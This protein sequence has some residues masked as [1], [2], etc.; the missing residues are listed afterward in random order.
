MHLPMRST[1]QSPERPGL[2]HQ[3]ARSL[4]APRV[5]RRGGADDGSRKRAP[6]VARRVP[7]ADGRA[8]RHGS[9][10]RH[11]GGTRERGRP[12][13]ARGSSGVGEP[14]GARLVRVRG[15]GPLEAVRSLPPGHEAEVHL[16]DKRGERARQDACRPQAGHRAP[17]RRLREGLRRQRLRPAV[18]SGSAQESQASEPGDGEGGTDRRQAVVDPGRLGLRQ[19]PLPDRQG[20][21][22]GEV[23]EPHVRRPLQGQD[24]VVRRPQPARSRRVLPRR[25]EAVRPDGRRAEEIAGI[26]QVEE[27]PRPHVLVV[28][29]RPADRLRRRRDL[30]RLC[31][32]GRLRG[33]EGEEAA[34]RLHATQGGCA[35]VG[36]RA[37]ARE[38][39]AAGQRSLTRTPMPGA[40][41][42]PVPGSRRT[43]PT[44]RRTRSR[45]P[46]TPGS[47]RRCSSTTRSRSASRSPTSIATSGG[48]RSTRS[49]GTRSRRP[50]RSNHR[51]G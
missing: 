32:A 47:A 51:R 42:R 38:G 11:R 35:L 36:L 19:D 33:D 5:S 8:G 20:E 48:G 39:L 22:E 2:T 24:R 45:G 23:L 37:D 10:R 16:H 43:T 13:T 17:M 29:D 34:G 31:L 27:G 9:S 40:R 4:I 41:R 30:D 7:A 1:A 21:A 50:E 46:P 3:R 26:S 18:E 44:A 49:S 6:A 14:A 28:R 25:Q 12:D 15:Q